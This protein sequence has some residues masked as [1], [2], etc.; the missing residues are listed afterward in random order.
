MMVMR[1]KE[2]LQQ[3]RPDWVFENETAGTLRQSRFKN[4]AR[5]IFLFLKSF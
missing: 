5:R 2:K 4:Q 3:K 1:E